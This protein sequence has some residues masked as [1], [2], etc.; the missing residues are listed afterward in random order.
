MFE[1]KVEEWKLKATNDKTVAK[2]KTCTKICRTE[3]KS[4]KSEKQMP[5]QKVAYG[6]KA[7]I[8]HRTIAKN[9]KTHNKS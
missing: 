7:K 3:A 1:Q 8:S 5:K 9:S 6:L 4:L 2:C